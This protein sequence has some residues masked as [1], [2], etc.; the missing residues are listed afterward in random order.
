MVNGVPGEVSRPKAKGPQAP[1]VLAAGLPQGT[2]LTTLH[3][4]LFH[5]M[6][7]FSHPGLEK[8]DFF[9]CRQTQPV[10]REYH[11]QCYVVEVKTLE[12]NP[13]ILVR[14]LQ[15]MYSTLW[16]YCILPGS[17]EWELYSTEQYLYSTLGL[18]CTVP[19]S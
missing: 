9:C 17:D 12:L 8:R 15:R 11:T 4:R 10:P 16:L 13:S 7:F 18:Y 19:W 2:P 6:S 5:I 3:P 1:R 14:R